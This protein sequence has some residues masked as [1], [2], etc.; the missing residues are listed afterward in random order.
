MTGFAPRSMA[1]IN[2]HRTRS[3]NVHKLLTGK[4]YRD[5]Q[6]LSVVLQ[7]EDVCEATFTVPVDPPGNGRRAYTAWVCRSGSVQVLDG[8][9]VL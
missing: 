2:E 3:E 7:T 8:M 5:V 9:P 1:A 4:G 6:L